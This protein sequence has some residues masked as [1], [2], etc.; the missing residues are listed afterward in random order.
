MHC[1]HGLLSSHRGNPIDSPSK[2]E[3][4]VVALVCHLY[5]SAFWFLLVQEQFLGIYKECSPSEKG[6]HMPVVASLTPNE[7]DQ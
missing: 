6:W 2:L 7:I 1:D 3:G 5:H 4:L